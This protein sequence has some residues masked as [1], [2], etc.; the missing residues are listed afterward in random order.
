MATV[1][2][3]STLAGGVFI[4]DLPGDHEERT[5]AERCFRFDKEGRAEYAILKDLQENGERARFFGHQFSAS[6]FVL[7]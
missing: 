1:L 5:G 4:E 2:K 6:D 3:F 7:A